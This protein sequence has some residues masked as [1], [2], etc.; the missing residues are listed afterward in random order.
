MRKCFADSTRVEFCRLPRMSVFLPAYSININGTGSGVC[1]GETNAK[2]AY[3]SRCR[4]NSEAQK[5]PGGCCERDR[6]AIKQAA[7]AVLH[8]QLSSH[9]SSTSSRPI[10]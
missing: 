6:L 8:Q 2:L 9:C 3:F 4:R 7:K 1:A 5:V 10:D